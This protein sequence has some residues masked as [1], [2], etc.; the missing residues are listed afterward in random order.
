[1]NVHAHI[2]VSGLVQGVGYRY[3]AARTAEQCAIASH[4]VNL[5]S[6]EVDID[7]QGERGMVEEFIK[8]LRIG[9]RAALVRNVTI[10]WLTVDPTL[11]R[12]TIQ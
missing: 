7:A 8:A 12:F 6:G 9:P 3:F 2:V 10:D 5:P 4:A 1:M 11:Q